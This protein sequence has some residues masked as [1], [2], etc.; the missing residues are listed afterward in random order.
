MPLVFEDFKKRGI[1][2]EIVYDVFKILFRD[3]VLTKEE[4]KT[5]LA[6]MEE[7]DKTKF[8]D[9]EKIFK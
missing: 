1:G 3:N 6:E 5:I 9:K 8:K 2:F 7:K 4:V